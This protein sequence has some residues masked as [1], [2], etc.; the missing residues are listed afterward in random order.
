MGSDQFMEWGAHE[1]CLLCFE[2]LD[3]EEEAAARLS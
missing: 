2:T 1:L 3:G